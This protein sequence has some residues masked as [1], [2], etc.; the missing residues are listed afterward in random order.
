MRRIFKSW[1][2]PATVSCLNRNTLCH[3]IKIREGVFLMQARRPALTVFIRNIGFE[4]IHFFFLK[5]SFG[6]KT[7]I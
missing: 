3:W 1:A 2:V 5:E 6:N 7:L 4:V